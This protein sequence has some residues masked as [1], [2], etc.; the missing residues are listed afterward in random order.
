VLY[1]YALSALENGDYDI[2]VFICEQAAQLCLKATLLRILGFIPRGHGLREL[3]GVL[4]KSLEK[5][6]KLEYSREVSR[7]TEDF[8]DDLWLLE[9]AYISARYLVKIYE[10]EDAVRSISV[11][12][13]LFKLLE[14]IEQ[15]VFS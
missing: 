1:N 4:S 12:E 14:V 2:A 8:R 10:R 11:I 6:G 3:L 7:F 13:K 9:D 5:L 15:D